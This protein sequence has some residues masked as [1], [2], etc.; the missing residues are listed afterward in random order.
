MNRARLAAQIERDIQQH[1]NK[2]I[3]IDK[4]NV[5]SLVLRLMM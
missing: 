5:N 4:A 3:Y 1:K 2:T